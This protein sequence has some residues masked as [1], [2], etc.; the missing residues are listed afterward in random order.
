MSPEGRAANEAFAGF[1]ARIEKDARVVCLHDTDADGLTAGVLWQ[2]AFE[3]LGFTNIARV[4]PGRERN[5]WNEENRAKIVAQSSAYL[6]VLDLGS[7]AV[8]VIEGV[9]T[10]FVDHHRPEGVPP[11][12]TLISAYA[13]DPIPCTSLLI[14][15]VAGAMVGL[16]DLDWIATI[17][18]LSDLG[19]NAPFPLI[20][21]AKKK[22]TAKY[23][24]EATTLVNA[25]R[26]CSRY[27][28][29]VAANA[30]LSYESPK[31]LVESDAPPI[32]ELKAAREEV[33]AALAEAKKAAPVFS[34]KVALIRIHSACVV[35]PLIAQIWRSRLPKYMVIVA[36][37]GYRPGQV[38]FSARSAPGLNIL[39]FLRGIE[40]PE[41]EGHFGHGHDQASGGI[42]PTARWNALLAALGFPE[43]VFAN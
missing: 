18:T 43:T 41:G 27:I 10:C 38:H 37:D 5:A 28:P 19:D 30:L 25:A 24:K 34:G 42:L 16:S 23:L 8:P 7:Q 36:N 35:H 1:V 26:R 13:W 15:Q 32:Q 3:R 20:A 14:Y 31:A 22:Y 21:E 9:P 2:R 11:G 40:I 29:E 6:F 12:D 39:E 17:G 4:L 33:A